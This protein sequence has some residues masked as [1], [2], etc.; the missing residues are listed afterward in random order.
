MAL[1]MLDNDNKT[2]SKKLMEAF[3]PHFKIAVYP[4]VCE[5]HV[6]LSVK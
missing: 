5:Q 3:C 4:L 1:A 2:M 6:R